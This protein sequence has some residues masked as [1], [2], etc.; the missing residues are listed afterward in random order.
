MDPTYAVGGSKPI[1]RTGHIVLLFQK[2]W[3]AVFLFQNY[4]KQTNSCKWK[5]SKVL[6]MMSWAVTDSVGTQ[7]WIDRTCRVNL[8][9]SGRPLF[10]PFCFG[11][12]LFVGLFKRS[13]RATFEFRIIEYRRLLFAPSSISRPEI[14]QLL[15]SLSAAIISALVSFPTKHKSPAF[16]FPAAQN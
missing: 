11:L 13:S 10:L 8:N 3:K 16:I 14:V 12:Y 7:L 15:K 5:I 6:Y 9:Y 4:T 1:S 2:V